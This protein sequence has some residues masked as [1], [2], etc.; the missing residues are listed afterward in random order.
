MPL[1][2]GTM[3]GRKKLDRFFFPG[4]LMCIPLN[5]TL[6]SDKQAAASNCPS[7]SSEL[8]VSLIS[9]YTSSCFEKKIYGRT[10]F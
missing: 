5:S 1:S 10:L 9:Q 4:T 8:S 3:G 2:M 6:L 7:S